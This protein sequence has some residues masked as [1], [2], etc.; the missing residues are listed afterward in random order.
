MRSKGFDV[1]SVNSRNPKL[2]EA[3][4]AQHAAGERLR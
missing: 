3:Q 1:A 2:T 4:H